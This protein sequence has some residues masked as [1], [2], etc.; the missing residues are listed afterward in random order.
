MLTYQT[1]WGHYIQITDAD[2]DEHADLLNEMI[3]L[4][5]D[6]VRNPPADALPAW[7]D[8]GAGVH[9]DQ[10]APRLRTASA[11]T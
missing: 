5:H 9:L 3:Q 4:A 11:Q 1:R 10:P 2:I 8:F 6:H 7:M